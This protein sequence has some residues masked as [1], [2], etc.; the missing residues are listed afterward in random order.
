MGKPHDLDALLLEAMRLFPPTA[1]R[2]YIE[3]I[4]LD[5]VD[6]KVF[7]ENKDYACCIGKKDGLFI[8][9]HPGLRRAPKYVIFFLICH[10]L[11]HLHIPPHAGQHHPHAFDI[12][13]RLLPCYARAC[14]YLDKVHSPGTLP[15]E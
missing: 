4:D 7:H 1:H 12:A 11:L 15:A 8:G 9:L 14:N 3:W 10:E 2:I 13:E 5:A 6:V